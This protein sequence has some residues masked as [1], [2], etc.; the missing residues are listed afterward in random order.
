M[1]ITKTKKRPEKAG[2]THR[3]LTCDKIE[4]DKNLK[5]KRNVKV[6]KAELIQS[7]G[8]EKTTFKSSLL[9]LH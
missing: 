5:T 7:F 3:Q 8:H 4:R 6:Q 2:Y 1:N 9:D